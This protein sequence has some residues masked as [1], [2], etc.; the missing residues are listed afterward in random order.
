MR[1]VLRVTSSNEH[2]NGGCEFAHVD[3]TPEFGAL[4]LRRIATLRQQKALDPDLDEVYYWACGF[5]SYFDPWAES[6]VEDKEVEDIGV[7]VEGM[8]AELEIQQKGVVRIPESFVVLPS[9]SAAVECEQI[10]VRRDS[11]AFAAIPKHASFRVET[12]EIPSAMLEAAA[13]PDASPISG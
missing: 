3:L 10:I 6:S 5:A 7:A 9:Q 2:C 13:D 8:L 11:I 4:A 1:I 12:A